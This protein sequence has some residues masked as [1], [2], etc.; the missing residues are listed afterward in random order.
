MALGL[1]KVCFNAM[2]GPALVVIFGPAVLCAGALWSAIF[3]VST[4]F[5]SI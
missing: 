4:A 2:I 1:A 5:S 3:S